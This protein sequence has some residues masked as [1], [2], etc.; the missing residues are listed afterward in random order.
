MSEM[1][2]DNVRDENVQLAANVRRKVYLP[3]QA[4]DEDEKLVYDPSAY[5]ML[6]NASTGLCRELVLLFF[7]FSMFTRDKYRIEV[8]FIPFV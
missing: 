4:M 2:E 5:V 8:L 1:E 3:G 6:H 7:F